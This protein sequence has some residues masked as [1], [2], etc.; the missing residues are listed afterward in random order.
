MNH[1]ILSEKATCL[2]IILTTLA[3]Y[4]RDRATQTRI[5]PPPTKQNNVKISVAVYR[6]RK[7]I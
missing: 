4:S 6:Y 2:S 7:A 1:I 3:P 5:K